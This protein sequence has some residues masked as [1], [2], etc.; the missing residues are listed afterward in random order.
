MKST[1]TMSII[2]VALLAAV[3]VAG[4]A[5]VTGGSANISDPLKPAPAPEVDLASDANQPSGPQT[6]VLA[7][8]CFWCTE[9]VFEQL[10]GVEQVVSGYAG[11]RESDANYESVL[12]GRTDHAEAIEI[13]YDPSMIGYETLLEVFFTTAHDPTQ[14]DRQGPDVGRQY[15]SA[16]FYHTDEQKQLAQAY[17]EQ[18][19]KKGIYADPIVTTLE[20]LDA[21]YP[22]EEYH[23]DYAKL[24]PY[25]PYVWQSSLPKVRKTCERFPQLLKEKD[26]DSSTRALGP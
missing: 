12:T 15:R 23:Q 3:G 5:F 11:G 2:G 25:N 8:G 7:G 21:F 9:A 16:I 22:A 4:Y 10:A 6:I 14:K 1:L 19:D 20:R 18:L 26:D 24:N 17:I 13:T